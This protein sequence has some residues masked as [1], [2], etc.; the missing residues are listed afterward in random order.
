[1]TVVEWL[2]GSVLVITMGL[3]VWTVA[4]TGRKVTKKTIQPLIDDVFGTREEPPE[5]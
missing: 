3:Y 4:S 1:M 5:K 2:F